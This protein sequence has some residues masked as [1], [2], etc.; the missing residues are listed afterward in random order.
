M[1]YNSRARDGQQG[2]FGLN[3]PTVNTITQYYSSINSATSNY[4]MKAGGLFGPFSIN[5]AV[6]LHIPQLYSEEMSL[7][8]QQQFR[9]GIVLDV[10]YVGTFTKHA[11]GYTPINNVPYGA[12]FLPQNQI[13]LSVYGSGTLPDN[14][15]RPYPGIGGINMQYF[16]LS[17][18]YNSLQVRVT[19]R[20]HNGLEFG[21]AYTLSKTMDYTDTYN[22]S[23][24]LYQNLRKW[25]YGPAGYDH[26]Q[27]L[28]VNY[29][30]SIPKGSSL[31]ANNPYWNNVVTREVLDGWQ[32]SGIA[33]YLS[34]APGSIGLSLSNGQN[35]AGGGDGV[36]VVLTCD[37]AKK[38]PHVSGTFKTW[39]NTSCVEPPIAGSVPT[40]ALP[41]GAN[42]SVGNG[43]MSPRVNYYLPG[44]TNFDTALFKNMPIHYCPVNS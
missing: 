23:V 36:R 22:G 27:N 4:Y 24:A 5:H 14:F 10:A 17:A 1:F 30:W 6:P 41:N 42:Y 37:P 9:A 39:F 25:N 33:S 3:A 18:N 12:E 29:L 16:N 7:G 32:I 19:R 15:F 44:D 26:R 8:V 21:G 11:S 38:V 31:F 35:V 28:V 13:N 43:W 40:A 34:G 2:D 20:F